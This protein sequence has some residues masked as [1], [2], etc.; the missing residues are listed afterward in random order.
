[1]GLSRH[2]QLSDTHQQIAYVLAKI[3]GEAGERSLLAKYRNAGET[4][5]ERKD[6]LGTIAFSEES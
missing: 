5:L 6:Y 2:L 4:A 1:M 3:W